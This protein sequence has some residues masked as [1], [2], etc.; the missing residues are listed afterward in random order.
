[1]RGIET[2]RELN[3]F[4]ALFSFSI[5]FSKR[6]HKHKKGLR[7]CFYTFLKG[8]SRHTGGRYVLTF[9]IMDCLVWQKEI[10]W[11]IIFSVYSEI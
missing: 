1:M 5:Y 4:K 11:V 2:S 10:N 6:K 7:F 3:T 9:D 8:G